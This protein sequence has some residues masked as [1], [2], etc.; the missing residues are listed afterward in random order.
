MPRMWEPYSILYPRQVK[1]Y[2]A[3]IFFNRPSGVPAQPHP[4]TITVSFTLPRQLA[5]AVSSHAASKLTNKSEIIRRAL[6][7]YLEPE[8]R[9]RI[10]ESIVRERTPEDAGASVATPQKKVSYR[11]KRTD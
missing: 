5:E 10:I 2:C 4:N 1:S 6:L 3:I 7:E 9:N 11:K 8:E